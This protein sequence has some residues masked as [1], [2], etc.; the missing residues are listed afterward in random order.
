MKPN[1]RWRFPLAIMIFI[2]IQSALPADL[3]S[4]QSGWITAFLSKLLHIDPAVLSP[5]VRKLAHFLEFLLL[6][7]AL[8]WAVRGG[9]SNFLRKRM[10]R[11]VADGLLSWIIGALYA[12]TDEIHQIFVPGRSCELRDIC[13]DAAGV[14]V[15]VIL[16]AGL[17][18]RKADKS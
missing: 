9:A 3:S 13:I 8:L 4:L 12:V 6:G 11:P 16:M 18:R 7:I 15:G 2:F 14:A 1:P 5:V 10:P 17:I